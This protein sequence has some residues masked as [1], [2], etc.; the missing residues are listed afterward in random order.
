MA[1]IMTKTEAERVA[2]EYVKEKESDAGC[3]LALIDQHTIERN[4][5]WVFFYDAKRHLETGDFRDA[6]AGNAPI[7]I[8]KA[9]GRIHET[10][11]A[12]PLEH[13]L[14]QFGG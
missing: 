4:F 6:L 8:T 3:E 10:G 13:Y 7:V 14:A 12:H 11:T 5:G 9:D 1:L 2:R